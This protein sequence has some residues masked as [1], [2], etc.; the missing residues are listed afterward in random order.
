MTG[1]EAGLLS[2]IAG[3]AAL[4]AVAGKLLEALFLS[5]IT[6]RYE[7]RRWLRQAKMES[8]VRVMEELVS[9]GLHTG[10]HDDPWKFKAVCAKALLLVEDAALIPELQ[11]TILSI[12][13]L[14]FPNAE[15]VDLHAMKDLKITLPDGTVLGKEELEKG[16]ALSI[17]EKKVIKLIEALRKDL[18]ST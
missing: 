14:R 6:D 8:Y 3:S 17:V 11:K 16:V 18:R 5:S 12:Y 15:G 13:W 7:R 4:G 1:T 2:T 9:L 10:V